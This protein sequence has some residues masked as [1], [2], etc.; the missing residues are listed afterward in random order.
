MKIYKGILPFYAILKKG[1][2]SM[3]IL[4]IEDNDVI[5]KGLEYT[6]LEHGYEF[7]VESTV[8]QAKKFWKK[9]L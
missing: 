3:K 2:K 4:L 1:A 8:K 7:Y 6:L 5:S 9:S